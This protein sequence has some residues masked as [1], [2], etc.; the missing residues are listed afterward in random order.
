MAHRHTVLAVLVFAAAATAWSAEPQ[1][2]SIMV[3]NKLIGYATTDVRDESREG[4]RVL[5]YTNRTYLKVALLGTKRDMVLESET[6]MDPQSQRPVSYRATNKTNDVV[7]VVEAEF[8]AQLARFW[9][10]RQGDDKGA[11]RE[12]ALREGPLLVLGSNNFCHWQLILARAAA[13]AVQGRAEIPAFLPEVGQVDQLV[14]V[15][16][17]S[18]EL[19]IGGRQLVGTVWLSA[20]PELSLLVTADSGEFLRLTAAQQRTIVERTDPQIVQRVESAQAE[21][22]LA[23]QFLQSN[24]TFDDFLKVTQLAAQVDVQVIGSGVGNDVTVLQTGMQVFAGQKS[25]DQVTGTMQ[26]KSVT[27]DP[28]RSPAYPLAVT[29]PA[30]QPYLTPA[31]CIESDHASITAKSAEL[32]T[33]ARSRWDAVL[34]I[35]RWVHQEI[36]Y[37]IADSPSARLAL[38]TRGR[39]RPALDADD[40]TVA[41]RWDP[42]A[43]GGWRGLYAQPGWQLRPTRVGRGS[44]GARRVDQPGSHDRRV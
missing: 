37:K 38:E 5:C 35:G 13:S 41:R 10:Y 12:T 21:E 24:V 16:G 3:G 36:A 23:S 14:L 27:Y 17:D 15:Q 6:V 19:Q 30:L 26:V 33:G 44:Y 4:Q 18:Q 28:A 43:P 34:A 29:D 1:Y 7:T 9:S 11:A 40:C 20:K 8:T 25:G 2:Y 42:R 39:L 31:E 32:V 22:V